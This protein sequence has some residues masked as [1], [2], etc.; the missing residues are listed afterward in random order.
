MGTELREKL[1]QQSDANS[2]Y[3]RDSERQIEDLQA[4]NSKLMDLV[5]RYQIRP[6]PGRVSSGLRA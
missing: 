4:E 2:D 3:Q 6:P 5:V 1:K